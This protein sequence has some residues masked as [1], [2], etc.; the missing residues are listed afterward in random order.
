MSTARVEVIGRR[1]AL[2]TTTTMRRTVRMEA[3]ASRTSR[4]EPEG[5]KVGVMLRSVK[6][7]DLTPPMRGALAEGTS[8]ARQLQQEPAVTGVYRPLAGATAARRMCR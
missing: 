6:A 4:D 5:A 7:S 1:Q 2:E 8:R 3:P